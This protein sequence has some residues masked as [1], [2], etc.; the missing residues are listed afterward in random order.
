MKVEKKNNFSDP[1]SPLIVIGAQK[2]GTATLT[3]DLACCNDLAVDISKKEETP[4]NYNGQEFFAKMRI[5]RWF[6]RYDT[7]R[8]PVNISTEYTMYP[9]IESKIERFSALFPS[10]KILYIV[11]NP[12]ARTLSHMHHDKVVGLVSLTSKQSLDVASPYVVNSLYGYQL[13]KWMN[14][15]PE[16]QVLILKFEDYIANRRST[17]EKIC[18][19]A[20]TGT[21]GI[22]LIDNGTVW[23]NTSDRGKLPR[24]ISAL[25]RSK[26]YRGF[27]R[28]ILGS[29]FREV[30]KKAIMS[31]HEI[32]R[33]ELSSYEL[34][35]LRE[36][37]LNDAVLFQSI[38]GSVPVWK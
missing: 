4:I 30:T 27:V 22:E 9:T 6:S 12:I 5:T 20:G 17:I 18:D 16:D 1:I 2:C 11:R 32:K 25:Q 24:S 8:I 36:L 31:R 3:R 13:R 37:F 7:S 10:A 34:S 23:N 38:H 21:E 26:L 15:F 35:N 19:F 29:G 28:P 14:Y 33:P